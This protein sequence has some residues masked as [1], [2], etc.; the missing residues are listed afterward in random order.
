MLSLSG[1]SVTS[2]R[3]HITDMVGGWPRGQM[4]CTDMGGGWQEGQM[5]CSDVT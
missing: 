5:V 3:S 4:L 1:L 2:G